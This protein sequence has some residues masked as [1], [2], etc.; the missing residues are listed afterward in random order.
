MRTKLF[1]SID[2]VLTMVDKFLGL[3]HGSEKVEEVQSDSNPV[4]KE[5]IKSKMQSMKDSLGPENFS[6]SAYNASW[7]LSRRLLA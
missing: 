2:R 5:F 3:Y 7:G 6:G 1:Q 4:S